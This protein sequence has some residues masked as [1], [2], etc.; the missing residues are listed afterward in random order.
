M[1]GLVGFVLVAVACGA[2]SEV[3][4]TDAVGA[5]GEIP[6]VEQYR[7][8]ASE[9]CDGSNDVIIELAFLATVDSVEPV[10]DVA[11]VSFEIDRWYTYDI[12]TTLSLWA[13]GFDGTAGDRWL[14][15]ASRY[16]VNGGASG[17]VFV[18]ASGPETAELVAEWDDTYDGSVVAGAGVA[19]TEPDPEVLAAIDEAAEVWQANRPETY[20][21]AF[22]AVGRA[23]DFR[24]CGSGDVRVVVDG[25][26]VIQAHDLSNHCEVP[27]DQVGS[28]DDLFTTA[29]GA[30]GALQ[31]ELI[32]DDTYGFLQGFYAV[33]RAVEVEIWVGSF[34]EGAFPLSTDVEADLAT[35]R[36]QWADSAVT[37][38]TAVVEARCFC[39]D[40]GPWDITVAGGQLVDAAPPIEEQTVVTVD[41]ILDQIEANLDADHIEVAFHPTLGYPVEA[42]IDPEV[43]VSDEETDF[44]ISALTPTP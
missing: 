7:D 4:S 2:S 31:D 13:D 30:A 3:V 34:V 36:Q 39:D 21:A 12:G 23:T 5:P 35:A 28:L 17:D 33:D 14:V 18:C 15:A 11:W 25:G 43:E 22:T 38:Y 1:C 10:G 41:Q 19:E 44:F 26:E 29:R 32:I 24:A 37:D 20:T 16:Q 42:R 27:A 9:F 6:S 40:V 8:T